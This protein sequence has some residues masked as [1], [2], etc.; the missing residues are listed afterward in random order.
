MGREFDSKRQSVLQE[1]RQN[2]QESGSKKHL[3]T[4]G[5]EK[6]KHCE[7]DT[8]Y[9]SLYKAEILKHL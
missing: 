3:L 6:T 8:V 5:S 4:R 2:S 1:G 7:I 9:Y